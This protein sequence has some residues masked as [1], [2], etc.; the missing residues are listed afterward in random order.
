MESDWRSGRADENHSRRPHA[1]LG[2]DGQYVSL[3][4]RC[5][6]AIHDHYLRPRCI[7]RGRNAHQLPAGGRGNRNWDRQRRSGISF[8]G[9][10]RI[11]IDSARRS[12]HDDFR[13]FPPARRSAKQLA[14]ADGVAHWRPARAAG[15]RVHRKHRALA[16]PRSLAIGILRR[17]LCR[18]VERADPAP[19]AP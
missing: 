3:L 16:H 19:P 5:A 8:W 2:G 14:A 17:L 10:N 13:R 4:S 9:Q 7:A 11:R 15:R 18:S 12:G 6:P 1:G